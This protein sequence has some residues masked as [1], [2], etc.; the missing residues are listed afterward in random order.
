MSFKTLNEKTKKLFQLSGLSQSE[1][2]RRAKVPVST[3]HEFVFKDKNISFRSFI[4]IMSTLGVDIESLIEKQIRSSFDNKTNEKTQ[5]AED[6]LVLINNLDKYQKREL[7]VTAIN[8]NKLK[9]NS[10]VKHVIERIE[11][12]QWH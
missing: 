9:N 10:K 4:Q 2:S 8:L 6:I 5:E 12:N 3:L 1:F 7:V 11:N